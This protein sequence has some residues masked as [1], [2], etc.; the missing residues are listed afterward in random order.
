MRAHAAAARNS[1][2]AA[3]GEAS[4]RVGEAP[5]VERGVDGFAAA[6]FEQRVDL[7][8]M[9]G[10]VVGDVHE[11][12]AELQGDLFLAE[13][14]VGEGGIEGGE[15]LAGDE[16]GKGLVDF[17]PALGEFFAGGAVGGGEVLRKA[18]AQEAVEPGLLRAH[19]VDK[20]GVERAVGDAAVFVVF[21]SGDGRGGGEDGAVLVDHELETV[22]EKGVRAKLGFHAS[23]LFAKHL[24]CRRPSAGHA[25]R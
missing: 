17:G 21:L 22:G 10:A 11:E 24:I 7:A 9:V 4:E 20:E 25:S 23:I 19:G 8:A 13:V 18:G 5:G 15:G 2:S 6:D 12:L 1:R 16:S 14:G 3:G